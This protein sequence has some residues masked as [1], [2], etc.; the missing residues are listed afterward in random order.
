MMVRQPEMARRLACAIAAA[1]A[2]S[3]CCHD[4]GSYVPPSN[5]Q[6]K[7][8]P[9]PKFHHV[10]RSKPISNT[11]LTSNAIPPS[12]D[13]LSNLDHGSTEWYAALDAINRAADDELRKKLVIC[14]GCEQPVADIQLSSTWPTRAADGFL[15]I[16]KTLRTLSLPANST[17]SSGTK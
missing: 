3:G 5:A 9:L 2:L 17:S 16:Q 15:S 13:E 12:G 10:K 14:R 4:I 6:A 1:I 11:T 7:F 8:A